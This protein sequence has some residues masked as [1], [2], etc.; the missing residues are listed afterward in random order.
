MVS[1]FCFVWGVLGGGF[2]LF[3]TIGTNQRD[4]VLFLLHPHAPTWVL[5]HCKF[6]HK[7]KD[8]H[9][10]LCAWAWLG[11]PSKYLKYSLRNKMVNGPVPF[12][13]TGTPRFIA[14]WR[15]CIFYKLKVCGN[16]A[17]SEPIHAVFSL[18]FAHLVPLCHNLVILSIVY[19]FS[20][21]YLLQWSVISDLWCYYYDSLKAQMMVNIF[22]SNKVFF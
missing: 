12:I 20:L 13:N 10:T 22:F 19:T 1:L 6:S 9:L 18:A 7:I 8:V 16:P 4:T 14:L 3:F 15:Y 5:R 11:G 21:S 2:C 17:S